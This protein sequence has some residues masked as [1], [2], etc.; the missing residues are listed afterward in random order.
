MKNITIH[1]INATLLYWRDG[2]WFVGRL[3][4][5]PNVFSQGKTLEE[6]ITNIQD[7]YKMMVQISL[8][9]IMD[10]ANVITVEV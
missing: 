1:K 2:N 7:A 8:D 6:L 9:E 3:V 5:I 10:N 4:E